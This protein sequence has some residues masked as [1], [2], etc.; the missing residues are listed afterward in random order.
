MVD[1]ENAVGFVDVGAIIHARRQ[2]VL[3]FSD[4][5]VAVVDLDGLVTLF[6]AFKFVDQNAV[7][8]GDNKILYQFRILG[9]RAFIQLIF[10]ADLFSWIIE[11]FLADHIDG[12][13]ALSKGFH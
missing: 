11:S 2:P 10:D 3:V 9:H 4:V 5:N 1:S 6:V 7:A 12:F 13:I 8:S